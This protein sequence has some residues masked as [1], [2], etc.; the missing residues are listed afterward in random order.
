MPV[1]LNNLLIKSIGRRR[2]DVQNMAILAKPS[3]RLMTIR[4]ELSEQFHKQ[5]NKAVASP[6]FLKRCAELYRSASKEDAQ[7]GKK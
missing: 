2:K 4:P 3:D 5:S 6:A 1:N 7:N